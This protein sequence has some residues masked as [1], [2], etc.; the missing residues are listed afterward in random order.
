MSHDPFVTL[1][2]ECRRLFLRHYVYF[3]LA[4][5]SH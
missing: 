3:H 2:L 5:D 1:A 4:V